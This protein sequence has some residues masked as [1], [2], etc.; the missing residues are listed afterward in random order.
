[1][2]HRL[3]TMLAMQD[4]MNT[5][6]HP[7]W[8]SQG[9]E[10]YRAAWIECGELMDHHGYKW[11]KKQVPDDE[12]VKLEII[13]IWHFGMSA[14]FAEGKSYDDLADQILSLLDDTPASMAIDMTI[15]EATEQLAQDCLATKGFSVVFFWQLMAAAKLDFDTLYVAYVGKNVLNFFRQDHGYKDGTYIKQWAGKEDNEHL[16]ELT[17]GLDSHSDSF[18]DDLYEALSLRYDNTTAAVS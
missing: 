8:I 7:Q 1:M 17:A 3:L 15:L 18:R 9:Y 14:L 5:K 11:W 12:Q 2:R 6:V 10:W 16:V 4:S 13:D